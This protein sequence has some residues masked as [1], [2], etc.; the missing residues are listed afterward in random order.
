MRHSFFLMASDN[1]IEAP[2]TLGFSTYEEAYKSFLVYQGQ[3]DHLVIL[4]VR[5]TYDAQTSR[6]V[7]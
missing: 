7:L 5:D 2:F 3:Y 1:F 6:S 4:E